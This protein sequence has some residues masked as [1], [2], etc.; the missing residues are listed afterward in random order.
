MERLKPLAKKVLGEGKVEGEQRVA[1]VGTQGSGKTTVLGFIHVTCQILTNQY[2][3]NFYYRVVEKTSGIREAPSDLRNGMFPIQTPADQGHIFEADF[4]MRWLQAFGRQQVRLPFC[5]TA[6]EEIQRLISRFSKGMYTLDTRDF[7]HAQLL[8]D[9]ILASNGFIVIAPVTRAQ[10]FEGKGMEDEPTDIKDPDVNISRLLECIYEYKEQN[11]ATVPPI[12]G[13]AVLL[14]KA[15]AMITML[16][17]KGMD[18]DTETGMRTFMSRYFPETNSILR[19]Y[20]LNKVRF[21]PS[22]VEL[23]VRRNEKGEME[24]YLHPDDQKRGYKIKVDKNEHLPVYS[25]KTYFEL[26]DWIKATFTG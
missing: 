13:I 3:Q 5:E 14:T 26:I 9:K 17:A 10:F 16:K 23:D 24:P 22:G 8:Y 18:L 12:K 7:Q 21:W 1:V 6:G 11:L 25:K 4:L 19:W 2:D 20:G 15:D